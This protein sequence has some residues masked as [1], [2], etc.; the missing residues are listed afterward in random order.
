[1]CFFSLGTNGLPYIEYLHSGNVHMQCLSLFFPVSLSLCTC[2]HS[3]QRK[4]SCFFSS[5]HPTSLVSAARWEQTHPGSTVQLEE[6]DKAQGQHL[7]RRQSWVRVRPLHP[8][9]PHLAQRA[10]QSPVQFLRRGDR[11]PPLQPEAHRHHLPCAPQVPEPMSQHEVENLQHLSSLT[12]CHRCCCCLFILD[13][14]T[15]K[16]YKTHSLLPVFIGRDGRCLLLRPRSCSSKCQKISTVAP[17]YSF[18]VQIYTVYL[19]RS[20]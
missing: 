2:S 15:I 1:M 14:H 10:R 18:K 13:K 3:L 19:I 9:F 20:K 5:S 6:R 12:K 16:L 4:W 8:L 17:V 11:L 7:H